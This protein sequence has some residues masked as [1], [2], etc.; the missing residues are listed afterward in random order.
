MFNQAMGMSGGFDANMLLQS[1]LMQVRSH[2]RSSSKQ[3]LVQLTMSHQR[4][5]VCRVWVGCLLCQ[6]CKVSHGR[7]ASLA[8]L[9][10]AEVAL[11]VM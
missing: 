11:V 8:S 10:G 1:H 7:F 3:Y 4:Y 6:T 5:S 9:V 2:L